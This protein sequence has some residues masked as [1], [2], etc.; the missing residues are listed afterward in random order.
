MIVILTVKTI[1]KDVGAS[2]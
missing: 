1:G 2:F